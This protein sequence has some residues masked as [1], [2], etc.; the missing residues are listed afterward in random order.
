MT[1]DTRTGVLFVCLGNICRSPL[2]ESVFRHLARERGVDALFHID[3]AGTAGYHVGHPPDARSAATASRRGISVD[4]AG[5]QISDEDLHRFD[6]V[7]V[8]DRANLA[9]VRRVQ[10]RSGGDAEVR[11]L[12]EWDPDSP[13]SDV[14]DPYYGGASGFE[15]VHDIVDRACRALLDDL[16]DQDARIDQTAG[17]DDQAGD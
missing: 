3:S 4:G 11:L 1:S 5:R 7:L 12:R 9:E 10:A 2:A 14:P 17:V 15:D 16:L 8:M 6:Y 13:G